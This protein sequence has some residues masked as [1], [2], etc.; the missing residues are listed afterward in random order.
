MLIL[1]S[2]VKRS[3]LPANPPSFLSLWQGDIQIIIQF[4]NF[5]QQ[6]NR[7]QLGR[8]AFSYKTGTQFLRLQYLLLNDSYH[9]G[10]SLF[11]VGQ[12]LIRLFV[13]TPR[14]G[15]FISALAITQSRYHQSSLFDS[16]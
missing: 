4:N 6:I 9:Y 14:S 13:E 7:T 8:Y 15:I 10:V 2:T 5:I 3:H 1:P 16:S 12:F 11:T